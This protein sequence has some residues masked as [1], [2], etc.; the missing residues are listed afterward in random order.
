MAVNSAYTPAQY[1]CDGL[2]NSFTFTFGVSESSDVQVIIT[3]SPGSETILTET[4]DYSVAAGT[5]NDFSG[6]G[7]VTTV[8]TY[9]SGYTLTIKRVL[10]IRQESDFVEGM[11]TLYGTFESCLD[12]LTWICQQLEEQIGRCPSLAESSAY[13]GL[14][15]PDPVAG[16]YLKTKSDLSGYENDTTIIVAAATQEVDGWYRSTMTANE[17]LTPTGNYLVCI[18]DPNGADRTLEITTSS[19]FRAEI[20]NKG[21][22]LLTFDPYGIAASIGAGDKGIYVYDTTDACW[23]G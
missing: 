19:S 23:M 6:G 17:T 13:S 14:S 15:L 18:M 2:T 22:Y 16:A 20:F 5:N 7:T 21:P 12:F 9:G 1:S 4:T 3:N 11:P 10:L 8:T